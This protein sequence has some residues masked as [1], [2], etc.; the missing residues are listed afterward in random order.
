MLLSHSLPVAQPA[1][2]VQSPEKQRQLKLRSNLNTHFNKKQ[3][4]KS[5]GSTKSK[6]SSLGFTSKKKDAVWQCVKSCGA[7]CKLDKG[8]SF[9][10][11]DEI[12]DDPSDIQVCFPHHFCLFSALYLVGV[13]IW[14]R[15]SKRVS[16]ILCCFKFT[17]V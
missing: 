10:S 12:F 9:P 8:P 11:P 6:N 3:G 16:S 15:V 5:K 7:C 17:K 2:T 4:S 14:G 1:F 13:P